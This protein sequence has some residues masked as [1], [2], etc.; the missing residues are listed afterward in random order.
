MR[1]PFVLHVDIDAFFA[2]VEVMLNPSLKGKPVIVGGKPDERGVVST[3]SYEARKSGVHSGMALRNAARKC[4]DGIFVRGRFH[5]YERISK[6]FFKCLS[7]FSPM[8]EVVSVDEA[9]IDL[10]GIKYIRSSVYERASEIKRAVEK[11]IG[12]EVSAGLGYTKLGAKLAT[13]AAKPGGIFFMDDE[14]E[15]ISGLSLEKIPGIGPHTLLILHGLGIKRVNE[16]KEKHF[17]LWKRVIGQYF[18]SSSGYNRRKEVKSRSFSRETTFHTDIRDV[19]MIKSHL[20]YLT[21]RL[22]MYLVRNGLYA[23][24]VEVKARFSDF[25]TFTKRSALDFPTFSYDNIW[26]GSVLLLEDLLK[27]R[28]LPLRLVGVKVEDITEKRDLLPFVSLRA[29]DLSRSVSTI[30]GKYGFSSIFTGREC[31]LENVYPVEKEG[32]VLKTASLTK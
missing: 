31:L 19:D 27:R 21:D 18:Y 29:E 5:I 12:L 26:K 22:S 9:Y 10:T 23:G 14:K 15:F 16:L 20:A 7:R 13:E 2:A 24:R 17:S 11:E 1:N 32:I 3:A 30:K 28:K 8:V 4:P 6:A 25:S